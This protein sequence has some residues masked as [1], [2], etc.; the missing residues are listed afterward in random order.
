VTTGA[1]A[2][3]QVLRPF[4]WSGEMVLAFNLTTFPNVAWEITEESGVG[5]HVG[6]YTCQG[7][8]QANLLTGAFAGEGVLVAANGDALFFQMT[9]EAGAAG[10]TMIITGGTGRFAGASGL[11]HG[12]TQLVERAQ[13]G[14][15]LYVHSLTEGTGTLTY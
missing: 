2:K 4:K 10:Y 3:N 15:V 6:T 9:Q 8:G 12:A 13:V 5:T 11:W 7:H 1:D 14:P